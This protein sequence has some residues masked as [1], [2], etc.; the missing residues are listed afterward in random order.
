MDEEVEIQYPDKMETTAVVDESEEKDEEGQRINPKEQLRQDSTERAS[1]PYII[2]GPDD[3][4]ASV[5]YNEGDSK[6][7]SESQRKIA[8][9]ARGVS[10]STVVKVIPPP[11]Q[12]LSAGTNAGS[13]NNINNSN[14]NNNGGDNDEEVQR[15]HDSPDPTTPTEPDV[16][17]HRS[18]FSAGI[19]SLKYVYSFFL[20]FVSVAIVMGAI[21]TRQTGGT[22]PDDT[23]LHPAVA[24]FIFWFL[25][26]WLAMM[27]GGQ[28]CLVGLQPI[29]K[30]KY[31]ETHPK[32]HRIT[33]LAHKGDNMERFIV[34]R[35]FL[36][37]LVVFVSNLMSSAVDGAEVFGLPSWASEIFLS[38]GLAVILTTI[39]LGQLTAQVN[40][41]SCMLDFINNYFMLF[42]T[43]ISLAMEFSGILHSVYLVQIV[44][45]KIAGEPIKSNEP[46]RTGLQKVFFW[47]RVAMSLGIL[48]FAFAVTLTALFAGNT[49]M[50]GGISPFLSVIIFF[51]LMCVSGMMEGM[52]IALFAVVNMPEEELKNHPVAYK[53][54]QLTFADSNLQA[55]LIG[56]QICVTLCTF[57]IAR[58]ATLN[59]GEEDENVF[60]VPD[61]FQTFFNTGLLGAVITTIIA[62]LAWRVI[63]SS[64]PVAFLSNPLITLIIR[65]CLLVE[66]SGICSASWALAR[67]QKILVGYQ[68]DEVYLEG[69]PRHTAD[70]VTRR[71]RDIDRLVNV[72]RFIYSSALLGF[73]IVVVMAA[74]FEHQTVGTEEYNIHAVVG[75]I[76]F[77]FLI[78]WLAMM[79]GG[80][81]SLVGLHPIDKSLYKATHP[82]AWMTVKIIHKGD[83]LDRFI[84]GR[85]FLVVVV[86]FVANFLFTVVDGASVLGLPSI[87]N[88]IFLSSGLAVMLITVVLGQLT[89]QVNAAKS[90]LDFINNHFM[91]FTAWVSLLVEFSGLLHAVYLPQIVFS[92]ITGKP[93]DSKEPPRNVW[94]NLFFWTRVLVSVMVLTFSFLVTLTALFDGKTT[95]WG[96]VRPYLAVTI[97]FVL[98][99]LIGMLEGLQIALFEV[100]NLP[101]DQFQNHAIAK[102][103]CRL[104][105][106]GSNLQAFLIGRQLLVTLFIFTLARVTTLDYGGGDDGTVLGVGDRLQTFFNTGMLGAFITTIVASL[107]WRVIAAHFPLIFLSNPLIYLIIRLCLFV[108][109]SGICGSAWVLGRLN[110]LAVGY[111]PDEVYLQGAEPHGTAPVTRRDKDVDVTI[112]MMKY[113]YSLALLV[114]SVTVL[115]AAIFQEQTNVA[116]MTTPLVAFFVFW[117]LIFCLGIMEGGQGCLVALEPIDP[118]LYKDSHRMSH[119]C[120]ALAHEGDNMR[121]FIVGR[122]FLVVLA[123]FMVNYCAAAIDNP[124]VL[125]LSRF[126]N[127]IFLSS[128]LAMIL[129]TIMWG[130]LAAQVNAAKC[131]LDFINNYFVL[132]A[133]YVSLAIEFSGLLYAAYLVQIIFSNVTGIPIK[134]KEP[135]RDAMQNM[136]FWFRI[137]LSLM[138]LGYS[139]AA[140]ITAL[141]RGKTTAWTTVQPFVSVII[142]FLLVLLVGMMEGAQIAIFAVVNVPEDKLRGH[143]IAYRNCKLVFAQS[144][145]EAFLIGRQIF[146]TTCMFVLARVSTLNYDTSNDETIFGVS[147]TLQDI[148]NTGFLGA[149]ITTLVASLA[150]R[151]IASA[152]PVAFLSNPLVYVIIRFCLILEGSGV[153][154]ASWVLGMILKNTFAYKPDATYIGTVEERYAASRSEDAIMDAP[155]IPFVA[156]GGGSTDR[157]DADGEDSGTDGRNSGSSVGGGAG[158]VGADVGGTTTET[159]MAEA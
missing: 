55:F 68:P 69:A 96:G 60:G 147:N 14:N 62:S 59:Y 127:D 113:L 92:K 45:S 34:G 109:A 83:N 148:F 91:I 31:A 43:Y 63:A 85:Q 50:W 123:V 29:D 136:V 67:F 30:E 82:Q 142:F 66:A 42:T 140:T 150:W 122:Q 126:F 64:F 132:L 21:F 17:H 156:T 28:G 119:K 154:S 39:M 32:T 102:K 141:F 112:L 120:T 129:I 86:V 2:H 1:N 89:A 71:D 107:I 116:R 37:V 70:P 19:E 84:I 5:G 128:G 15:G 87:V 95:V 138:I 4:D 111:Q 26:L 18:I 61:G 121:R 117:G 7:L 36:V 144:N 134:S 49:T 97:F 27:E 149:I 131:M 145:L 40:A 139:F 103:N 90:M 137:L 110:K 135:P 88:E 159:T 151:M 118:N 52:Q 6:F 104:A 158:T 44:F 8:A 22:S 13:N 9:V 106:A 100:I 35:Q 80:Q 38:S 24:F 20:L 77:W 33:Q 146:V 65:I 47:S 75:C 115:M 105:F 16:D 11:P 73:C 101:D 133:T 56:R 46:P 3:D 157:E 124:S 57:V 99:G 79:E 153:C 12:L 143:A 51:I 72:V 53:N 98:M 41:T 108:E 125:G 23:N 25:I 130:Q 152:F 10:P 155:D 81:G 48:S 94:Q 74:I 54:C 114:F 58:V 78:V 93:I 76:V